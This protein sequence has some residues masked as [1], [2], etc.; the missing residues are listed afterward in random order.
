M[1]PREQRQPTQVLDALVQEIREESMRA[2]PGDLAQRLV[3]KFPSFD[4][5][6]PEPL[7]EK[8]FE[9]FQELIKR[10]R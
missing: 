6:W 10:I 3:D 2:L 7:C 8:W 4:P 9:V 1:R 5:N